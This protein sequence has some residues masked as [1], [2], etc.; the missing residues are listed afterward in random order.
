MCPISPEEGVQ[1]ANVAST[2]SNGMQL[3]DINLRSYS[4]NCFRS[5]LNVLVLNLKY[6]LHKFVFYPFLKSVDMKS[7]V[8]IHAYISF[9]NKN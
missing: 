5:F 7:L 4:G 2:N 3:I 6:I 8:I 9:S 1:Q